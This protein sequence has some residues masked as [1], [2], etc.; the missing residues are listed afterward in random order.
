MYLY[1]PDPCD[2]VGAVLTGELR[3]HKF[4]YKRNLALNYESIREKLE[5]FRPS[6]TPHPKN[7]QWVVWWTPLITWLYFI[8]IGVRNSEVRCS[9]LQTDIQ[10][11]IGGKKEG[12]NTFEI[13]CSLIVIYYIWFK[14]DYTQ[15]PFISSSHLLIDSF[16]YLFLS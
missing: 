1:K 11:Y 5:A 16:I 15:F 14:W 7:F 12:E 2:F 4:N 13:V 9:K 6:H 3:K 10:F 8:G